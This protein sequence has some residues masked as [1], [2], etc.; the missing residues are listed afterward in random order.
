M[1]E[2]NEPYATGTPCWI[3]LMAPDHQGALDFYRDL[4]GWEGEIGPAEQGGYSV[5]TKNGR[6][7]AGIGPVMAPDAPTVWTTYISTDDAPATF[8]AVT[9]AGGRTLTELMDVMT[10]GQMAVVED[11]AGAVFGIWGP[12]DFIGA[13]IVNEP[14]ALIWNECNTRDAAA[15][16]AFYSR[17]FGI[18]FHD[19]EFMPSYKEIQVNGRTVGGL[20]QMSEEAFGTELP[21][22]WLSY[23]AVDDVDSTLDA[24][25][26]RNADVIMPAQDTPVGRMAT[27]RDP[28]GAV[29]SVISPKQPD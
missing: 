13:Q 2:V 9:A 3:D 22:H 1:P 21:S 25:V 7:V 27:I 6:P 5:C 29:F 26:K 10:L 18:G 17:V 23:F 28:W 8:S 24:A 19:A 16:T 14:G 4:F 11:P 20:Q 12:K 15:A